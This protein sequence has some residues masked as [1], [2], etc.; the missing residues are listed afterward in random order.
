[1]K[2]T[3]ALTAVAILGC[4]GAFA[5]NAPATPAAPSATPVKHT[6]IKAC[7]KQADG[8]KL[9]GADRTAF[10]KSCH[11]GKATG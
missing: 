5:A 11:A 1:M 2:I 9:T 6:S 10:V 8:K 7:N 4:G 3:A